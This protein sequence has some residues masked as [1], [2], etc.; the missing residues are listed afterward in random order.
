M[1]VPTSGSISGAVFL[2]RVI[3][4][5]YQQM[6]PEPEQL[7]LATFTAG[8]AMSLPRVHF[9]LIKS[10]ANVPICTTLT[11]MLL[12]S[13]PVLFGNLHIG[14]VTNLGLSLRILDTALLGRVILKDLTFQE[15][16]QYF[17]SFNVLPT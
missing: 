10:G 9:L 2:F 7:I 15:Y 12:L 16:V 11:V 4:L 5:Q 17:L 13:F 14:Y 3:G 1:F 8:L 6:Q